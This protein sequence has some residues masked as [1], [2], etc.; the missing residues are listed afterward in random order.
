M[1]LLKCPKCGCDHVWRNSIC[2]SCSFNTRTYLEQLIKE[3]ENMDDDTR[4]KYISDTILYKENSDQMISDILMNMDLTAK[5]LKKDKEKQLY[6]QPIIPCPACGKNISTESDVCV[7]CGYPLKKK[8]IENG[9]LNPLPSTP[10]PRPS[11]PTNQVRCP[12]CGSTSIAT[13]KR[14]FDLMWGFLESEWVTY[15]VCQKCGRRWKI[16]R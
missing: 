12:K 4:R 8:L 5:K 10:C 9:I 15:N 7:H 3:T 13:E 14:G 11:T 16:G 2:S 1:T 6:N